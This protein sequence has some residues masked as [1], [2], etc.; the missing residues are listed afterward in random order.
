[1]SVCVCVNDTICVA[2]SEFSSVGKSFPGWND[3]NFW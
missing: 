1:M 2:Q 3:F